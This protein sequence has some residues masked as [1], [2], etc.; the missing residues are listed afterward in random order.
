MHGG[1]VVWSVSIMLKE[2][3]WE[4]GVNAISSDRRAYDIGARLRKIFSRAPR[5][6]SPRIL[7]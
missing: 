3:C 2:K 7:N 5:K 1:I 4:E 6:I